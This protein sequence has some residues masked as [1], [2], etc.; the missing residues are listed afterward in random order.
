MATEVME[1]AKTLVGSREKTAEWLRLNAS[2]RHGL[3]WNEEQATNRATSTEK[4]TTK[5]TEV[6]GPIQTVPI[7]QPVAGSKI[8]D[9]LKTAGLLALSGGSAAGLY[10]L[11]TKQPDKTVIEQPIDPSGSLLQY[12]EDEGFHV[13]G[14]P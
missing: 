7:Q 5:I 4:V 13:G 14:T 12:L 1:L 9:W 3:P 11:F 6:P 8:P 2:T 10:A